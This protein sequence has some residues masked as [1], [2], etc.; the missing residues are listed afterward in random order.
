L[1]RSRTCTRCLP[2]TLTS[3]DKEKALITS[4]ALGINSLIRSPVEFAQ[5]I[6]AERH[7][8]LYRLVLDEA[9]PAKGRIS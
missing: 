1:T 8:G 2:V 5:F 7:F 9:A 3:S 6:E 4:N